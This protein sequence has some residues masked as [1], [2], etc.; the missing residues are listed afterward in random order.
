MPEVAKGT[1]RKVED[2][3]TNGGKEIQVCTIYYPKQTGPVGDLRDRIKAYWLKHDNKT[4]TTGQGVVQPKKR[5]RKGV[6]AEERENKKKKEKFVKLSK[7]LSKKEEELSGLNLCLQKAWLDVEAAR[8]SLESDARA[9]SREDRELKLKSCRAA[10]LTRHVKVEA[11]K[12][13]IRDIENEVCL[14]TEA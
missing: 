9:K 6:D 8:A 5:K 11:L 12:K 1:R 14:E 3:N 2:E 7:K 4:A 10:W 13:G